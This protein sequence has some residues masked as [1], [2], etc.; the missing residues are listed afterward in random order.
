MR[1]ENIETVKRRYQNGRA[2]LILTNDICADSLQTCRNNQIPMLSTNYTL[3]NLQAGK[4]TQS[5]ED[6]LNLYTVC[7]STFKYMYNRTLS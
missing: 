5:D 3:Q 4:C 1:T 7:I 2:A 6:L